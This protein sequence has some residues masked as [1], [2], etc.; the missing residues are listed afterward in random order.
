MSLPRIFATTLATI[1]AEVPYLRVNPAHAARWRARLGDRKTL[2]VGVV[3]AGS[4]KHAND[5]NRSIPLAHVRPLLQDPQVRFFGLHRE[6]LPAELERELAGVDFLNLG[7][8]LRDFG[9]TAAIIDQLD[10]LI[11]VDTSVVHVGGALGKPVW[12]LLAEPAEYRW[13]KEREDSPWYPTVR[14]FRQ[15]RPRD[16]EDVIERV[17][18]ELEATGRTRMPAV[19][20]AG[21]RRGTRSAAD[22]RLAAIESDVART[23]LGIAVAAETR[24]G[25][26]QFDPCLEHEGRSLEWYGE[27]LQPVLEAILRPRASRRNGSR[28]GKR[29]WRARHHAGTRARARRSSARVRR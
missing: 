27:Y 21:S 26:M 17:A 12:L 10:L 7:P 4:A 19:Q 15:R 11:S 2:K 5:A 13:L 24:A 20:R 28:G 1:P 25:L 18:D 29:P 14:L 16:W 3:W 23:P 22:C 6:A 8:E 9:D